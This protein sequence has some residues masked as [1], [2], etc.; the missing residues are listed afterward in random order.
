MAVLI[1]MAIVIESNAEVSS[2]GQDLSS[3]WCLR[4]MLLVGTYR[5]GWPLLPSR[6]IVMS[7]PKLWL[8]ARSGSVVLLQLGSVVML[9]SHVATKGHTDVH[10]MGFP[11]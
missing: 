2:L 6:A 3:C 1:S 11:L 9:M 5:S 4:V 8:R 7:K 10:N